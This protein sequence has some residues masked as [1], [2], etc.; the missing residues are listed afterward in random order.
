MQG[1]SGQ[2][3]VLFMFVIPLVFVLM[4]VVVDGSHA[5]D[6]RR[7][8]QNAA[9]ATALAAAYDL[10]HSGAVSTSTANWYSTENN[11]PGVS[12]QC[13]GNQAPNPKPTTATG[14]WITPYNNNSGQVEVL[15]YTPCVAT[16]FGGVM[17]FLT[18][19]SAYSCVS[20]SAY[21]IASVTSGGPPPPISF[22]ALD[23]SCE[24]HTL[25]IKLGGH[26]TVNS[27]IYDN[28][29][30]GDSASPNFDTTHDAFDVF[31]PGGCQATACG[32]SITAP[33]ISTVGGWED[34]NFS[35]VFAGT[36]TVSSET[37]CTLSRNGDSQQANSN[38]VEPQPGCPL[39]GQSPISDP[40]AIAPPAPPVG[41]GPARALRRR[42][43][44][45]R[46]TR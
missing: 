3:L 40:F 15:L 14:C 27:G 18:Q 2:T 39:V 11:G 8:L 1:E 19:T 20:E 10:G 13:A 45:T 22:A 28:S 35:Q 33:L 17:N 26:L 43:P 6:Q 41:G 5:F 30:S 21:A 36:G 9:D 37:L 42:I 12:G 4:L 38:T 16:F 44:R 25:L 31:G 23:N 29:C 34:H 7:N 46:R 24:H 32:G